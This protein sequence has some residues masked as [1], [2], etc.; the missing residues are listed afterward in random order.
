[1]KHPLY[2]KRRRGGG[3]N[4][5]G[6]S[7]RRFPD[8]RGGTASSRTLPYPAHSRSTQGVAVLT[9]KRKAVCDR[10]V[11]LEDSGIVNAARYRTRTIPAAGALLREEDAEEKQIVMEI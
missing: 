1:M 2:K 9:L 8:L 4:G 5:G 11:R 3:G 6:G 7:Q 10:A